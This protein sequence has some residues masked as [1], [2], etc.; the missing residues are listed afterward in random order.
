MAI[1][2][3]TNCYVSLADA[4]LFFSTHMGGGE[5][6]ASS[7][8]AREAALVTATGIIDN[9]YQFIGVTISASQTLAWPRSGATYLD[10]Q[11]NRLTTPNDQETPRRVVLAT[12]ELALHLIRNSDALYDGDQ[13]FEKIKIGPIEIQDNVSNYNKVTGNTPTT[14]KLLSP[15]LVGNVNRNIWWRAN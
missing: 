4:D 2:V 5:W 6:S 15:L 13:T 8:Q 7:V 14:R 9:D 11:T 1:T 3:G 10:P 12:L